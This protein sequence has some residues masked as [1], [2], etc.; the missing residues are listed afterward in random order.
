VTINT[1]FNTQADLDEV[2]EGP[3]I[4]RY[5]QAIFF[6]ARRAGFDDVTIAKALRE[7]LF[8]PDMMEGAPHGAEV[9]R[10]FQQRVLAQPDKGVS[11]LDSLVYT[12]ELFAK[13]QRNLKWLIG[14]ELYGLTE[15]PVKP[16]VFVLM[17]ELILPSSTLQSAI[18]RSVRLLSAVTDDL[19]FHFDRGEH[20]AEISV[21]VRRPELD[22]YRF[23]GEWHLQLW[24]A[25][26]SWLLGE[27]VPILYAGFAHEPM[28][29]ISE[30]SRVFSSN[31]QFGQPVDSIRFNVDFLDKHCIRTMEDFHEFLGT[32]R[33]DLGSLPGM[34]NPLAP[35]ILNQMEKHFDQHR[36]LLSMEAIAAEYHIS[37]QTLRRRLEEEGVSFRS[38]KD[39]VR[40]KMVL[41]FLADE[42]IPISEVALMAGFAEPSGL[43][44][45]VK[46]W[47]GMSPSDYRALKAREAGKPDIKSD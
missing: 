20:F 36:E 16:G 43:S 17:V 19:R 21:E 33:L 44:R 34:N 14:D 12:P 26:M 13:I 1:A 45:V 31:C 22:P 23:L 37:S 10:P 30:Y 42:S 2:T 18:S 25:L 40:K 28:S 11:E 27:K 15:F 6:G 29:P 35:R 24:Q 5:A 38:I 39:E 7:P 32:N 3:I 8:T 4:E 9:I 41:R 47:L 46:V